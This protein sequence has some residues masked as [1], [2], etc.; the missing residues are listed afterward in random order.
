MLNG[1]EKQT[2]PLTDYE[3]E[4]L[5][6]IVIQGLKI[7]VG[8]SRAITNR[9]MTTNLTNKGYKVSDG[10]VRK[11]INHIRNN[12]LVERLVATSKGYFVATDAKTLRDYIGTLK[13]RESAIRAMRESMEMQ[14]AEWEGGKE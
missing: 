10:R 4:I 1:F 13:G 11:L 12:A 8:E 3:R 14:L 9:K 2:E 7:R 6:P 5:L